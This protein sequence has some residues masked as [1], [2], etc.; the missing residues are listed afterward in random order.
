MFAQTDSSDCWNTTLTPDLSSQL[1]VT[2]QCHSVPPPPPPHHLSFLHL[3]FM[4]EPIPHS[5]FNVKITVQCFVHF[6]LHVILKYSEK[7][8]QCV[9]KQRYVQA[10]FTLTQFLLRCL[11]NHFVSSCRKIDFFF[12]SITP[13][14]CYFEHTRYRV[15]KNKT[16]QE[17]LLK[18]SVYK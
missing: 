3:D 18:W 15:Y 6:K 2:V 9:V 14:K 17:T 7:R 11:L 4:T 10:A 16:V 1:K 8:V 12:I 13:V 5:A